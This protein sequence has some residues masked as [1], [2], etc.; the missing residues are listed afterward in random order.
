MSAGTAGL[1]SSTAAK[2][3][4]CGGGGGGDGVQKRSDT[5]R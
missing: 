4:S 2:A 3:A 1:S 5:G